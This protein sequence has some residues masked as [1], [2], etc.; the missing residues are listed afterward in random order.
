MGSKMIFNYE[1]IG[2][3]GGFLTTIAFLPQIF[4]T[5][6]SKSTKDISLSMYV[7]YSAGLVLWIVY[8]C[9]INSYSIMVANGFTLALAIVN[10]IMKLYWK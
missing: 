5:F 9:Y 7:I 8:A 1:Y 10:V 2:F 4:K 6:K 3:A